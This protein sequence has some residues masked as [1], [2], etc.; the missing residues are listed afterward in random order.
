MLHPNRFFNLRKVFSRKMLQQ[1]WATVDYRKNM[2]I[3]GLIQR[4]KHK[5]IVAI[6]SYAKADEETAEVAFVV[7]E[8][9]QNQGIGTFLVQTLEKIAKENK[10][11]SFM[12]T[13]LSENKN[14]IHVFQKCYPHATL[15]RSGGGD[16]EIFM[17]F[18]DAASGPQAG[19]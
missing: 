5:E 13:V 9:Y 8:E 12:A 6:G 16:V 14:M 11:K 10:Y 2:T 18:E 19:K 1:Q 7:K 15:K 17:P 4:G 3:I